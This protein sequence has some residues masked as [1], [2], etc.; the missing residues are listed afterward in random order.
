[1]G[2]AP[3]NLPGT[4]YVHDGAYII[5]A[6][7]E[8]LDKNSMKFTGE[9]FRKALLEVKTFQLPLTGSVTINDNHTVLKPVYL[10]EVKGGQS[11]PAHR[12]PV[13]CSCAGPLRG[14]AQLITLTR[15]SEFALPRLCRGGRKESGRERSDNHRPDRLDQHRERELPG[16]VHARVRTRPQGYRDLEL[17]AAGIDGRGVLRHL[18]GRQSLRASNC[19]RG[20][21]RDFPHRGRCLRTRKAR[22]SRTSRARVGTNHLLHIHVRVRT[23]RNLCTHARVHDRAGIHAPGDDVAGPSRWWR[24]CQ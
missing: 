13:G 20:C 24:G 4:Q 11:H 2:R 5:K 7:V 3:N 14:P 8:H 18:R 21:A 15:W 9:N 23:V 12:L 6:L 1:M 10:L 19:A 22:L 16:A 17:Y